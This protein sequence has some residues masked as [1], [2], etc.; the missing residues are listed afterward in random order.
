MRERERERESL[1]CLS[2]VR[3]H[4]VSGVEG[5]KRWLISQ[6]KNTPSPTK[7]GI[8]RLPQPCYRNETP[9]LQVHAPFWYAGF[10]LSEGQD[11]RFS[12]KWRRDS[13]VCNGCKMAKITAR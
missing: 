6:T 9:R 7:I 8:L 5:A 3:G 2:S 1:T 10:T 11:L 13:K 12:S 4:G